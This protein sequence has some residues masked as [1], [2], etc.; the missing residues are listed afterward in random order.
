M[1]P[2]VGAAKQTKPPLGVRFGMGRERAQERSQ[3]R[4][5]RKERKERKLMHRIYFP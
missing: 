4:K 2:K 5:E 3:G 1:I